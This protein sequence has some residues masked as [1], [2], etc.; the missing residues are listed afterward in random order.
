M[1][2]K[3]IGIIIFLLSISLIPETT[4]A[5]EA[6]VL[7]HEQLS[8]GLKEF[9]LNPLAP[10]FDPSKIQISIIITLI[11]IVVY[12]LNMVWSTTKTAA[13]L[14]KK[15]KKTSAIGP[16]L[17]RLAVGTSLFI[18]AQSDALFAPELTISF[19]PFSEILEA[20]LMIISL[21]I[22]VG[23]F[24]E[25]AAIFDGEVS[26]KAVQRDLFDLVKANKLVAKGDKRWRKYRKN[27]KL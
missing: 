13:S 24:T 5:H 16:L 20:C 4:F 8:Q 3:F 1:V 26:E 23:I 9:S 2:Q 10:L 27:H 15:I 22:L 19:L 12:S 21:M 25:I 6:Y 14:D 18:G 7:S 17:I 11:V